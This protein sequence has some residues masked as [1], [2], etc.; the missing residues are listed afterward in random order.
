[1]SQDGESD[2]GKSDYRRNED[3]RAWTEHE[4]GIPIH[5][6]RCQ[7]CR[8]FVGHV[9][10]SYESF[11]SIMDDA[12]DREIVRAVKSAETRIEKLQKQVTNLEDELSDEK[13]KS[14]KYRVEK[15]EALD[16][17][18]ELKD[19][20]D[21]VHKRIEKL[22]DEVKD[23]EANSSSAKDNYIMK[24]ESLISKAEAAGES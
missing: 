17:V 19:K 12:I 2:E 4:L 13:E 11:K 24:L 6:H 10:L 14:R 21:T 7:P 20:L 9:D 18:F 5:K 23:L 3:N 22:T 8:E 16:E 1:M 15:E